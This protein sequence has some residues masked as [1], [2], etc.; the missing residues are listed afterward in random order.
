MIDNRGDL[1]MNLKQIK[2]T[3]SKKLALPSA[4]RQIKL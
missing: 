3:E 4:L 2:V 1:G